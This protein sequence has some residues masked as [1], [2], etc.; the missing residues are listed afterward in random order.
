MEME[1]KRTYIYSYPADYAGW[2]E[3]PG[4]GTFAP[5]GAG[6][7]RK[8]WARARVIGGVAHLDDDSIL[9]GV[10]YGSVTDTKEIAWGELLDDYLR[11]RTMVCP[12]GHTWVVTVENWGINDHCPLCYAQ[13]A[14]VRGVFSRPVDA[15]P[16][17]DHE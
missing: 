1:K 2:R 3:V 11:P 6:T 15:P 17:D 10:G 14:Y 7:F 8:G 16:E 13:G 9:D 5:I 12:D 4:L